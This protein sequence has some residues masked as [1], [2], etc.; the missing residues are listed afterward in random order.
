MQTNI[1]QHIQ[2]YTRKLIR[3]SKRLEKDT[4]CN[5]TTSVA[6]L[7]D[8]PDD[9]YSIKHQSDVKKANYL[10]KQFTSV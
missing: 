7:Y 1:E 5:D 8:R 10:Q 3:Q 9:K 4:A 6:P 2:K